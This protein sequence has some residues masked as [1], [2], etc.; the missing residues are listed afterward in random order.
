MIRLALAAVLLA[1]G[2]AAGQ[3]A[4]WTCGGVDARGRP[5]LPG[6][7]TLALTVAAPGAA[8]AVL[9]R[10]IAAAGL[11]VRLVPL[12]A[13]RLALLVAPG[14]RAALGDLL[15]PGRLGFHAER[16]EGGEVLRPDTGAAL[17]V[18]PAAFLGG[19]SVTGAEAS[20]TE[21]GLAGVTVTLDADGAAALGAAS[22]ALVGLRVAVVLDG[23][24]LTAPMV[25][26]PIRGGSL[27]ISGDFTA[28]EAG[29][30]AA[31]IGAGELPEGTAVTGEAPAC[32]GAGQ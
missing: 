18:E 17:R 26:E 19:G 20:V 13:G 25:Q 8:S 21:A 1:G 28:G 24:V 30:L 12:D 4:P 32:P 10:R 11:G 23:R 15:A 3:G 7:D 9:E 22:A 29:A 14:E 2:P 5:V 31:L 27:R 6:A 16:A